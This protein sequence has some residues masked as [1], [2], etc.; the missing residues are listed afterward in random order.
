AMTAD[1][2]S[3]DLG[4]VD[5]LAALNYTGGTT[6][7]PKG[8][9]HTQRHMLYTAASAGTATDLAADGSLV[10]LCYIPIFWIA[11]EDLGLLLPFVYGGTSVLMSRWDAQQA[12]DAIEQQRVTLMIGTVENYL[13]L[14]G[15]EDISKRD[16]SSLTDPQARSEERRVGHR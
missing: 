9:Q 5:S 13:E 2:M 1:P 11:G 16:F 10:T 12:A 7:L 15:L 8:C 6:G 4:G 3:A 14:M